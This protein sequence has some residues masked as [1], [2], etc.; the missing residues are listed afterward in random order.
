MPA[1][2]VKKAGFMGL[3]TWLRLALNKLSGVL[4]R[5]PADAGMTGSPQCPPYS[6]L[7]RFIFQ[8]SQFSKTPAKPKQ[9]AF[10]PHPSTLKI[11]ALWRD[12]LSEQE[13]WNIGDLLGTGRSKP[14]LARADFDLPTVSEAKLTIEPDPL[15]KIP[16]HLNLCGWPIDKAEQKSIA[17]LL[18]ARSTLIVR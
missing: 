4:R 14:P 1:G 17:L 12:K 11:S 16:Q 2:S 15:P 7:A 13:I 9:G 6:L 18:C 8:K 3:K 5:R 10:L